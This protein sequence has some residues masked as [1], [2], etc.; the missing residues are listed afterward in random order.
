MCQSGILSVIPNIAT[1]DSDDA[2]H[3]NTEHV[4]D[5]QNNISKEYAIH[6]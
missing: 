3:Q 2:W 6:K 5:A 1:I 4:P